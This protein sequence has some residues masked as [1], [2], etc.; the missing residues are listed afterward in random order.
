MSDAEDLSALMDTVDN[1][2]HILSGWKWLD[3]ALCEDWQSDLDNPCNFR[4]HSFSDKM[5]LALSKRYGENDKS[6][7]YFPA[8][9]ILPALEKNMSR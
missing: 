1:V 7:Y 4:Q 2:G 9:D 5:Y 6:G 8:A 3:I